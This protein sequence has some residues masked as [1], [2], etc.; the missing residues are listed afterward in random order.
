MVV[1]VGR[2]PVVVVPTGPTV[3]VVPPG[4][5]VVVGPPEA[6]VV[7]EPP[8]PTVVVEP[9]EATVVVGPP[10]ATVVVVPEATVVV[11]RNAV[12]VVAGSAVGATAGEHPSLSRRAVR[13]CRAGSRFRTRPRAVWSPS[14]SRVRAS[15]L[16][17]AS[18]E[19][20]MNQATIRAKRTKRTGHGSRLVQTASPSRIIVSSA[21]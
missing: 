21:W 11:G 14:H 3:V 19:G 10:E 6:T 13:A 16:C 9:P 5:T 15:P 4:P 17:W 7:V 8:G 2:G 12:V 20:E 1:V 18:A